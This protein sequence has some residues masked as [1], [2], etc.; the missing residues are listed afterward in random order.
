MYTVMRNYHSMGTGHGIRL[1]IYLS[2]KGLTTTLGSMSQPYFYN[3]GIQKS[4]TK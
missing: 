3:Y 1:M 2:H 4:E